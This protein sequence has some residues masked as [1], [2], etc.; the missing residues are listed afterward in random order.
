MAFEIYQQPLNN[1]LLSRSPIIVVAGDKAVTDEDYRVVIQV[2]AWDGDQTA[3]PSD[4]I[5]TLDKV[6]DDEGRAKFN[7]G[8]IVADLFVPSSP[9]G[10]ALVPSAPGMVYNLVMKIG[11][12]NQ[13]AFNEEAQTSV[14]KVVEGFQSFPQ[15]INVTDDDAEI[16]AS[17]KF[18]TPRPSPMYAIKGQ[19]MWFSAFWQGSGISTTDGWRWQGFDSFGSAVIYSVDFD[20]KSVDPPVDSEDFV[21]RQDSGNVLLEGQFFDTNKPITIS[22]NDGGQFDEKVINFQDELCL[23]GADTIAFVNRYGVWDW[24]HCYAVQREGV[25]AERVEYQSRISRFN[26]DDEVTYDKH[27]SSRTVMRVKGT[28]TYEVNTGWITEAHNELIQDMMLSKDWYSFNLDVAIVLVD[29]GVQ[30]KKDS[31]VDLINYTFRFE[32]GANII[33]D[34]Q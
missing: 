5:A 33:Q 10:Y 17:E 34:I 11:W 20:T 9:T 19:P 1:Y 15:T 18:L 32:V 23:V 6:Q 8:Q 31:D 27:N 26:N 25:Q 30:F 2:F 24:L 12:T 7:I 28:K 21:L 13:G 14:R 22:L 29:R 16:L 3:I 4:P